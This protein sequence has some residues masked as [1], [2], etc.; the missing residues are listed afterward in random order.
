MEIHLGV[1][2]SHHTA[3]Q[4]FPKPPPSFGRLFLQLSVSHPRGIQITKLPRDQARR[5]LASTKVSA[6]LPTPPFHFLWGKWEQVS[7]KM[8]SHC[9]FK[10]TN[11]PSAPVPWGRWVGHKQFHWTLPCVSAVMAVFLHAGPLKC[12]LRDHVPQFKPYLVND[13]PNF[14]Q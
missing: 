1:L 5:T 11:C 2:V 12:T 3:L 14:I 6:P 13:S 10:V 8:R 9:S 7:E 4:A